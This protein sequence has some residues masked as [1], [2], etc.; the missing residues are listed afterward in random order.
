MKLID[1]SAKINWKY[2][3]IVVVLGLIVGGG[4]L[5]YA[6]I[7]PPAPQPIEIPNI[8][9]PTLQQTLDA[10]TWQTYRNDEFGFEV[11][12]PSNWRVNTPEVGEGDFIQID[13]YLTDREGGEKTM[14][15]L[16][17]DNP[18][19]EEEGFDAEDSNY[20]IDNLPTKTYYFIPNRDLGL[21]DIA[22]S[23]ST[24]LVVIRMEKNN[25]SYRFLLFNT[26]KI[27]GVYSQILSTFRFVE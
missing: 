17:K 18:K 12:Y 26:D 21:D 8:Q 10:S 5:W 16:I 6:N 14:Q 13:N 15:I 19:P 23:K 4:I 27:T 1:N 9:K 20:R 2:L 3:A 7:P 24:P 25:K 11:R 22:V